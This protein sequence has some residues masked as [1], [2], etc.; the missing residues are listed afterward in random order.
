MLREEQAPPLPVRHFCYVNIRLRGGN[1]SKA[2]SFG[3]GGSTEHFMRRSR[4]MR[5]KKQKNREAISLP[6]I[7]MNIMF[8]SIVK[9]NKFY[10]CLHNKKRN[11]RWVVR[12]RVSTSHFNKCSVCYVATL[13]ISQTIVGNI[14]SIY[15]QTLDQPPQEVLLVLF[16]Q[17]KNSNYYFN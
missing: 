9:T 11:T 16:F 15:I 1:L 3:E 6:R 2:F 7:Q 8:S 5:S 13:T 4:R 17:E 12:P 14:G 10:L